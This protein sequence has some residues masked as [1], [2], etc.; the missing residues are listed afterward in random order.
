M[1]R[2]SP[3]R[4]LLAAILLLALA[5]AGRAD[6]FSAVEHQPERRKRSISE[7]VW[8]RWLTTISSSTCTI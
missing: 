1:R 7:R 4:L 6:E 2:T 3:W 8:S 5:E